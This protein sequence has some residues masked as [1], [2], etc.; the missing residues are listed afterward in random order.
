MLKSST[1]SSMKHWYQTCNV[2]RQNT[3]PVHN[4]RS[5]TEIFASVKRHLVKIKMSA[6]HPHPSHS[7]KQRD[8]HDH[9][10]ELCEE[11]EWSEEGPHWPQCHV[12]AAREIQQHLKMFTF[13]M[14]SPTIFNACSLLPTLSCCHSCCRGKMWEVNNASILV[15]SGF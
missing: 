13:C 1:S 12:E 6:H 2:T 10:H 11:D 5:N 9:A 7:S 8:E 3:S 15:Y 4:L 14:I